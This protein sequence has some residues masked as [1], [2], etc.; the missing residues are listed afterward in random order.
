[1]Y[2]A[3]T[4]NN[5]EIIV[6]FIHR[7]SIDL[8]SFCASC[9]HA[10]RIFGFGQL[11]GGRSVVAMQYPSSATHPSKSPHRTH[12]DRWKELITLMQAF[13]RADMV[14]GDLREPNILCDGENVILVDL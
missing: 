6:K 14:H 9:G 8:H 10:P 4:T 11:P 5:E 3:K 12:L 13:H 2:L 1:M 7:Y